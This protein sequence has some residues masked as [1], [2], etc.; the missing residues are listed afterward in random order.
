MSARRATRLN[1]AV[2]PLEAGETRELTSKT[3]TTYNTSVVSVETLVG[4]K[5]GIGEVCNIVLNHGGSF[6]FKEGQ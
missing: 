6:S 2:I 4:P 3:D 5:G 1:A